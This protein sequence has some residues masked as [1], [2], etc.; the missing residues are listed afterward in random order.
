MAKIDHNKNRLQQKV[1]RQQI[2]D[3]KYGK[4]T[5]RPRRKISSKHTLP[6]LSEKAANGLYYKLVHSQNMGS[7][8]AFRHVN[9]EIFRLI[10]KQHADYRRGKKS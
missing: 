2:A 10:D 4:K 7:E 9:R 6:K 5:I 1:N 3:R 8:R